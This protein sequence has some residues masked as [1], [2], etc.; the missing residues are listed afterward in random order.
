MKVLFLTVRADLGG[1]PEHLYQLLKHKP[2]KVEAFV[3]C[4]ADK[5]YHDRY[6]GLVGQKNIVELPH[7]S[8]SL[9]SLF[10]V[11]AFVRRMNIDVLHS[12]GKG[13]GLYGRLLGL[14]TGRPVVHTFHGLH[15]GDY[16][17]RK[18]W[19]YLSLE[20][21]LGWK[22]RKAI[23]VSQGEALLVEKAGFIASEKLVTI[24]NGIEIPISV[25]RPSWDG[26]TLRI[27]A[28]NR[29]DHQKNPELLI[30]I[31]NALDGKI[32]FRLDVIGTGDRIGDI[33]TRVEHN[34]LSER[35]RIIGGV[36]NPRDYF[37]DAHVFL[38]TSRWEGMPLAVLEAMSESLCVLAT[39]VVGNIDVIEPGRT[40]YLFKTQDEAI[41][42]LSTLTPNALARISD[43]ARQTAETQYSASVMAERTHGTLNSI[44]RAPT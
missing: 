4:P 8:F 36:P 27:I 26:G 21:A 39:E 11:A 2:G 35:V 40:G 1:G 33:R 22:T 17:A 14:L 29:Y 43:L 6:H 7:R 5:P 32:D 19:L 20:R 37:R 9:R 10:K 38:S 31:A 34:G 12:H 23:C 3:A 24:P 15:V 41:R 18:K 28:V 30:D 25:S 13:A 42:I 16:S 44:A